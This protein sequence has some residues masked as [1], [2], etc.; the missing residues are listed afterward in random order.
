M[1]SPRS[2]ARSS[3]SPARLLRALQNA[4]RRPRSASDP[5]EGGSPLSA[6]GILEDFEL[7][8][9]PRRH[10]RFDIDRID[11]NHSQ[12]S[13]STTC[14]DETGE[15]QRIRRIE[16][17]STNTSRAPSPSPSICSSTSASSICS[18]SST[19]SDLLP[20]PA[21]RLTTKSR[22][23]AKPATKQEAEILWRQFWD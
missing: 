2:R 13:S 21:Q 5:P 18:E 9:Y 8:P 19:S 4:G 3:S 15:N 20:A 14:D 11:E 1:D 7:A 17:H 12:Q 22:P 16:L 10:N 6:A 23:R